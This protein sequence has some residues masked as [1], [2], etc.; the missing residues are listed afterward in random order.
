MNLRGE[1]PQWEP[2]F[3]VVRSV[4]TLRE[5]GESPLSK[6][7]ARAKQMQHEQ[8]IFNRLLFS[9]TVSHN[10]ADY[11]DYLMNGLEV[12]VRVQVRAIF[13]RLHVVQ[14]DSEVNSASYTVSKVKVK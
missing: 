4:T 8:H 3:G 7:Y 11:T 10:S 12:R 9:K 13:F 5:T 6:V 1:I 14:T 2:L